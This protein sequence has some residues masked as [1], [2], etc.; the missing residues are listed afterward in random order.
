MVSAKNIS[1][2]EVV[3]NMMQ[4][5]HDNLDQ[6]HF[7]IT[8]IAHLIENPLRRTSERFVKIVSWSSEI[9]GSF[10]HNYIAAYDFTVT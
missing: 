1:T 3:I 2:S 7:N 9:N 10:S 5:T 4:Y 6:E 8:S